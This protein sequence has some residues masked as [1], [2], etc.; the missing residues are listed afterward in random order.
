[1]HA[2]SA[3]RR[4]G[5][6]LGILVLAGG[7]RAYHLGGESLW[8]DELFSLEASSGRSLVHSSVPAG[9]LLDPPPSLTSLEGA[10]PWW[11]VWSAMRHFAHPPLYF[12]LLRGWRE[13]FGDGETAL[14]SLSLIAALLGLL[15]LH[16]AVRTLHGETP[17]RWATLLMAV[18]APQIRYGQEARGYTLL[19]ALVLAAAAALARIE[20]HGPAPRRVAALGGFA[21]LSAFT[22][23]YALGALAGLAGYGVLRLRGAARRRMLLAFG[24]AGAVFLAAWG[25]IL[26]QQRDQAEAKVGLMDPLSGHLERTLVRLAGLPLPMLTAGEPDVPE[27]PPWGGLL[28][29]LAVPLALR[30]RPRALI[31]CLMAAG[32]AALVTAVD[33]AF[34]TRQLAVVRYVLLFGPPVYVLL[35]LAFDGVRGWRR[36]LVPLFATAVCVSAW[37][38]AYHSVTPPWRELSGVLRLA[39]LPGEVVA[40]AEPGWGD[41]EILL[42]LS[43][44]GYPKGAAVILLGVAGPPWSPPPGRRIVWLVSPP[45]SFLDRILSRG[46]VVEVLQPPDLPA[47]RRVVF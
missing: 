17:A 36:H 35:A 44:Y 38:Q 21:F 47:L 10:P 39:V 34:A 12:L 13:I 32:V 29:L 30:R 1:M 25:P 15:A 23:Y 20:A 6:L 2:R 33:L 45:T 37:P 22:H 24:L 18:A 8:L 40:V 7:L 27:A 43:H 9:V 41:P 16:D 3:A 14:R 46:R 19:L 5:P 11:D 26:W 42:A 4:W 31:W 28:L